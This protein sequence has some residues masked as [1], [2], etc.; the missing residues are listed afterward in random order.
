MDY[1]YR[2]WDHYGD[3]GFKRMVDGG[4]VCADHHFGYTPTYTGP[5]HASI[6]T[7]TTPRFHGI[8]GNNWYE[9]TSDAVVYCAGDSSVRVV[10]IDD[11]LNAAGKMSPRRM[12][13]TTLG[14]E[15]KLATDGQSK[16]IGISLKDRGAILPAG[17]GADGAY[18]YHGKDFGG[19]ISS[20]YYFDELPKWASQFNR[21]DPSRAYLKEGWK[22]LLEEDAYAASMGDNNPYEGKPTGALRPTF[23]YDLKALAEQN[24]GYDILK[25]VPAGNSLVVDFALAAL[26]GE[27]LG[28]DEICDLLAISF[29][30]TDYVGHRY[31]AHAWETQ[32]IYLR[33][34]LELTRLFEALDK[35]V[36]A[37]QW[38]CFL[39]A[40]HGGANVPSLASS[41]GHPTDYWLPGNLEQ[42]VRAAL[43][44]LLGPG[45]WLLNFSNNQFFLDRMAIV[46][47]GGELAQIEEWIALLA[48]ED[49]QV[50]TAVTAHELEA[51]GSGDDFSDRLVYGQNR[52]RSGEVTV[53]PLPGWIKYGRTGTTHGSPFPYDTHVPCLFY[54]WGISPGITYERTH[55]RDIAPTVAHLIHSP[56]PNAAMGRPIEDLFD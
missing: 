31:G 34:D 37:G 2:Y 53:V 44:S 9:R 28:A 23:P 30:A 51:G 36:G 21:K 41:A 10:G 35:Q 47:A 49:P 29:S 3:G 25:G 38:T 43:D 4:F 48:L 55:I 20:T 6:Y 52:K 7:G 42:E 16:V 13:S 50:F 22:L 12:L 1:L 39:T 17:H 24:D 18:W 14:D 26:K 8:I 56:L 27:A 5:G 40:D 46:E 32:D 33:L 54:G 11:T 15:L 19:F 45:R